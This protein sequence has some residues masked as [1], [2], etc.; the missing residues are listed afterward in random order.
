MADA[1]EGKKVKSPENTGRRL[2]ATGSTIVGVEEPEAMHK[3]CGLE[4]GDEVYGYMINGVGRIF[5]YVSFGVFLMPALLVYANQQAGCG[6]D[7]DA[8]GVVVELGV[9][10]TL[11]PTPTPE[12][13]LVTCK[14]TV[15]GLRP[16]TLIAQVLTIG[17]FLSAV[18]QP[19]IGSIV[20]HSPYRKDVGK[21][22][23]TIILVCTLLQVRA[24][25]ALPAHA[26]ARSRRRSKGSADPSSPRSPPGASSQAFTFQETWFVM[27]LIEGVIISPLYT[28]HFV[29][30]L[31]YL[32]EVRAAGRAVPRPRASNIVL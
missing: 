8:A 17:G 20:D 5:L 30:V 1:A 2:S 15:Y 10:E 4:M 16:V 12:D 24:V 21:G 27:A 18:I 7:D 32:P 29:C 25:A 26:R 9:N 28:A 19:I 11:S 14:E 31:A 22:A 6:E 3:L 23:M 13:D